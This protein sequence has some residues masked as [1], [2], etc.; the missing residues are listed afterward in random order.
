MLFQS[1]LGIEARDV[2]D[3]MTLSVQAARGDVFTRYYTKAQ[4]EGKNFQRFITI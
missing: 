4:A 3:T 2:T 1:L